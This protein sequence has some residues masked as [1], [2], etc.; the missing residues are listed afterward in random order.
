MFSSRSGMV[1]LAVTLA[2]AGCREDPEPPFW[3]MSEALGTGGIDLRTRC[4]DEI[5]NDDDGLTDCSD[6]DC[7]PAE[8][9]AARGA[10]EPVNGDRTTCF[11]GIDN[12]ENGYT[13]CKDYGCSRAPEGYCWSETFQAENTVERCSDGL[14]NDQNSYIDCDDYGCLGIPGVDICESND[15][16]C[17]DGVD[18][19][20]DGFTDCSDFS[21]KPTS[22]RYEVT[23]CD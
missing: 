8:N 7:M 21:C 17:S 11:D 2:L 13:D 5:D 12:D 3:T 18:N 16:S 1:F 4:A 22:D 20:G 10:T 15:A 6:P 19:D 9:C 23:V 14:D